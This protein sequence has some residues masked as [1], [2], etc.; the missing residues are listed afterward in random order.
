MS[1]PN[2]AQPTA[3]AKPVY[4]VAI[5]GG[6]VN[7]SGIARDLAGRGLTVLLAE[8]ADLAQAT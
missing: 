6:G 3:K 7:G 4:D 5:I 2:T 8:Q 1:A